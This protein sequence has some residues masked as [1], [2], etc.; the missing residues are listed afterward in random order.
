[1]QREYQGA[2][3]SLSPLSLQLWAIAAQIARLKTNKQTNQSNQNAKAL[4]SLK[5]S[6]H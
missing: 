6:A 1:M 4:K 2:Q 5:F 3:T